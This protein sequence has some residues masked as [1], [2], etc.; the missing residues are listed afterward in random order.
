ML[1]VKKRS[2]CILLD[3][4]YSNINLHQIVAVFYMFMK[5][6]QTQ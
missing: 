4:I 6:I 5:L 2:Y 1:G 3:Y